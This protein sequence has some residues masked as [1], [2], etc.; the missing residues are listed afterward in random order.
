MRSLSTDSH[1][2][3]RH[4]EGRQLNDNSQKRRPVDS[5]RIRPTRRSV[6]ATAP[7]VLA[8]IGGC[9][10]GDSGSDGPQ[11]STP[12]QTETPNE[13]GRIDV[14][15]RV[16]HAVDDVGC[17]PTGEVA[18]DTAIE[19]S[20]ADGVGIRFP[21]GTYRFERGH[22]F[23]G[24]G[25][26]GLVGDGDVTFQPPDG[27]NDKL[28]EITGD[29][30]LFAGIDLDLRADNTTAGLRFITNEGFHVEDVEFL[31]RGTHEDVAVTNALSVSVGNVEATGTIRDVVATK[32]SAIAHYGRGNGR[33][34]IWVGRRHNGHVEIRDCR[35][36]EFG[37]NGIYASRAPGTTAVLG[38]RFRNNNIAG[39]RL[40]GGG[41]SVMGA[42]IEVDVD[43]YAGPRTRTDEQYNT[44]AI[45]IEQGPQSKGGRVQVEDCDVRLQTV[46]RSQG[47]LVVWSTGNGP[48]IE[49]CHI[50]TDVDEVSGVRADT[51]E[52]DVGAEDRPVRIRDT[53]LDGDGAHGSA[54][55]IHDRPRSSLVETTVEQAGDDQDGVELVASNP[56]RLDVTTITASRFSILALEAVTAEDD[57]IVDLGDGNRLDGNVSS[58]AQ[59]SAFDLPEG[60]D[61]HCIGPEDL[62]GL[63][64]ASAVAFTTLRDGTLA[65]L[66]DPDF[67]REQN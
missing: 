44:R 11:S 61:R 51:P 5:G 46:D 20:I 50:R 38:G 42:T 62:D 47:A 31:G 13:D 21:A 27:F 25:R 15:D 63:T 56:L 57:C 32:G 30:V 66:G 19:G 60:P 10:W 59:P 37:N 1:R 48:R 14:F 45:V 39:V 23:R 17:D 29:R 49:G 40:G 28:I 53:V 22:G 6:L 41:S 3:W 7:A 4:C 36:E 34:G 64:D 24:I 18:C 35:L 43:R 58:T 33:V 9:I 2:Q 12:G 67:E 55:Q 26:L 65:W 52:P 16:L 8:S 54:I